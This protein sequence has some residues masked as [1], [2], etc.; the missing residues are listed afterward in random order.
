M[1]NAYSKLPIWAMVLVLAALIAFLVAMGW[2]GGVSES[3]AL[4][5]KTLQANGMTNAVI[6]PAILGNCAKGENAYTF[7]ALRDGASISG[8]VCV[9]WRMDNAYIRY[10]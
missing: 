5:I 2:P 10:K 6:K 3:E 9:N 8:V 1:L 4:A 7:D